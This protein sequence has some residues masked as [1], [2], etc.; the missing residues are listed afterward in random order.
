MKHPLLIITA[1][2]L[3]STMATAQGVRYELR[4]DGLACPF[5]AYG[6]EKKFKKTKGVEAVDIDLERG[7][8]VVSAGEGVQLTREQVERIV[9]DAGFTLRSMTE[10]TLP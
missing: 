2:L 9:K 10:K 4:V 3:W 7:L 6:I 1:A 5:C 8:V